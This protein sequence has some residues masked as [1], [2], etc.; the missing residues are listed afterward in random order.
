M[1]IIYATTCG[2]SI[3]EFE[4]PRAPKDGREAHIAYYAES[5]TRL[6]DLRPRFPLLTRGVSGGTSCEVASAEPLIETMK[7]LF[8]EGSPSTE[9]NDSDGLSLTT[10]EALDRKMSELTTFESDRH[11]FPYCAIAILCRAEGS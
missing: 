8:D 4:F 6:C 7:R 9:P 3:S 2:Q 11:D 1:S 10:A 5:G